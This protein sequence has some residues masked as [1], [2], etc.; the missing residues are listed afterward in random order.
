MAHSVKIENPKNDAWPERRVLVELDIEDARVV[1]DVLA[2]AYAQYPET[3]AVD[4]ERT[5][6]LSRLAR[7]FEMAIMTP[8]EADGRGESRLDF[9]HPAN[10][11]SRLFGTALIQLARWSGPVCLV[12]NALQTGAGLAATRSGED[13]VREV[14]GAARSEAAS[15]EWT[16]FGPLNG[17]I[18]GS[19]ADGWKN[20]PPT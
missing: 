12:V 8:E 19:I 14:L 18:V 1:A 20:P 9:E 6:A 3:G 17:P 15:L 2:T 11:L 13:G 7:R 4:R 10:Q 5:R 16:G